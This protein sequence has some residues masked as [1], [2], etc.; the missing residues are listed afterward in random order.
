MLAQWLIVYAKL[1]H[2]NYIAMYV[3]TNHSKSAAVHSQGVADISRS[4]CLL[5]Q[6]QILGWRRSIILVSP[7]KHCW[8]PIRYKNGQNV[9]TYINIHL[10]NLKQT[11]YP[12]WHCPIYIIWCFTS[13]LKDWSKIE[14]DNNP[15]WT[16][17]P[18][19]CTEQPTCVI[20]VG[21]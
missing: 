5:F 6:Q 9:Y 11:T 15:V 1:S 14:M 3:K 2:G 4:Y 19:N 8:S 18:F 20:T 17:W 12:I 16:C 10:S 21:K 13:A 7:N